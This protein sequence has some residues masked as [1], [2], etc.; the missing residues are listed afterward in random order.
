MPN[1][2]LIFD[3]FHVVQLT[4]KAFDKVGRQQ[5]TKQPI[6]RNNR[7]GFLKDSSKWTDIQ[8]A[9]LYCLTRSRLKTTKAWQV[10]EAL[11]ENLSAPLT[12]DDAETLTHLPA[13]PIPRGGMRLVTHNSR[14]R[15]VT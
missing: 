6:L 11:R 2:E 14:I 8:G 9:M 3:R 1:A 10:K 4:N 7:W 13:S 15:Q 12:V 5:V